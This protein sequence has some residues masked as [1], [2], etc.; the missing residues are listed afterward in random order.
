MAPDRRAGGRIGVR[1]RPDSVARRTRDPRRPRLRRL[2]RH[3]PLPQARPSGAARV[4]PRRPGSVRQ[5]PLRR[6]GA[7]QERQCGGGRSPAHV[8]G[9]GHGDRLRQEGRGC[10][11]RDRRRGGARRRRPADLHRDPFALQPA[12]AARDLRGGQHRR[13]PAGPD[14]H[15]RG[16]RQGLRVPLHRQ[17]RRF[18][19]QDVLLPADPVGARPPADAG[20][21]R[22]NPA[23]ARH[24]G[25]SALSPVGR[26]R[27]SLGRADPQDGEARELPLSRRPSHRGRPFR[28]RH[29]RPRPGAGNPRDD[30]PLRDRRAIRR[31]VFLP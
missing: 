27:R 10:L 4:D 24:R 3:F 2:P 8:P 12:G 19:E 14:R 13:Q 1:R 7:A 22:R 28:P 30:P 18:G 11:D 31:Q 9:H 21:P 15:P 5:R 6:L 23:D 29:T 25:V 26:H 20:F 16:P 17:G